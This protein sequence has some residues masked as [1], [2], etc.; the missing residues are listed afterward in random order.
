MPAT[1]VCLLITGVPI[2]YVRVV[3]MTNEIVLLVDDEPLVN[4][5]ALTFEQ[6]IDRF[7]QA[8]LTG[9]KLAPR[10]ADRG[11]G[12]TA[13]RNGFPTGEERQRRQH[14]PAGSPCRLSPP[15]GP[16]RAQRIAPTS[17]CDIEAIL[18]PL[19]LRCPEHIKARKAGYPLG[20]GPQGA[21]GDAQRPGP[22]SPT[23][24]ASSPSSSGGWG[25]AASR[26][27]LRSTSPSPG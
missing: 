19:P 26:M 11:P 13:R 9:R 6:A 23:S 21:T 3:S 15:S 7:V 14:R 8:H 12:P 24:T 10:T 22:P 16:A 18:L 17:P 1:A 2:R 27:W 20:R 5:L 4:P 25:R